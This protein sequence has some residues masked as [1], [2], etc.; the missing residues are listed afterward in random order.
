MEQKTIEC[1]LKGEIGTVQVLANLNMIIEEMNLTGI[2]RL[3]AQKITRLVTTF[4]I[5]EIKIDMRDTIDPQ[6]EILEALVHSQ[7]TRKLTIKNLEEPIHILSPLIND[8]TVETNGENVAIMAKLA[9]NENLKR[10]K[11]VGGTVSVAEWIDISLRNRPIYHLHLKE[12]RIL[13][14]EYFDVATEKIM[15]MKSENLWYDEL[16]PNVDE[17][18]NF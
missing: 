2:E 12:T 13:S 4:A 15:K 1:F 5:E 6:R 9:T 7:W 10:I 14:T 16:Y 17:T 11:C 18:M 8:I 3:T